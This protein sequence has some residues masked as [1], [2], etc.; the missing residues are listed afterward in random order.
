LH[1]HTALPQTQISVPQWD[2]PCQRRSAGN[3]TRDAKT[4]VESVVRK[5][6]GREAKPCRRRSVR[7]TTIKINDFTA[8]KWGGSG[9]E[10]AKVS[11][12]RGRRCVEALRRTASRPLAR[13]HAPR[14]ATAVCARARAPLCYGSGADG[15]P[16]HVI[17]SLAETP[18]EDEP[19]GQ[20]NG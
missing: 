2:L 13:A 20:L 19:G 14:S 5:G 10:G 7:G 6:W 16:L 12:A 8:S 15:W 1:R 9:A 3:I 18:S 4:D 11:G 17:V